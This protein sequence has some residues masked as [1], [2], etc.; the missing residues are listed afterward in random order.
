MKLLSMAL[1]LLLW[2][3]SL[4]F[5]NG[6]SEFIHFALPGG[7]IYLSLILF[8][9]KNRCW[10]LALV[11]SAFI[12]SG[13]FLFPPLVALLNLIFISRTKLSLYIFLISLVTI[14]VGFG[15]FIPSSIFEDDYQAKQSLIRKGQLYPTV[16]LARL[17]QNKPTI[18]LDKYEFNLAALTDPN[19]YFFGFHP[20]EIVTNNQNLIKFPFLT[21]I[22]FLIGLYYFKENIHWKFIAAVIA[23][24]IFNLSLLASFDKYDF[25]L[26]LP[27]SLIILTGFDHFT[28]NMNTLKKIF[29]GVFLFFGFVEYLQLITRSL[30]GTL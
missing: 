17:F 22:F 6:L 27:L 1:I 15:S 16:W 29:L 26:F 4:L 13:L 18:Y 30:M 7:F 23:A 11:P 5:K 20:R 21:I 3:L 14:F 25:I 19:N 24:L 2:P 10:P 9:R 28:K 8:A 12:S